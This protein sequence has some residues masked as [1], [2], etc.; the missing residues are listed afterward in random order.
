MK[1]GNRIR[2]FL[3]FQ[4]TGLIFIFFVLFSFFYYKNKLQDSRE[5]IF[6]RS[7]TISNEIKNTFY[8][9]LESI[10]ALNRLLSSS[11]IHKRD[12]VYDLMKKNTEKTKIVQGTF[13]AFD[14]N[15]FDYRDQEYK[16]T[17]YHD[18]TGRV[19][20]YIARNKE[21]FVA[22]EVAIGYENAN[23][24]EIIRDK[25]EHLIEPYYDTIDGI[26]LQITSFSLPVVRA[27]KIIGVVG[28]DIG[29]DF[30]QKTYDKS[31]LIGG[32]GNIYLI[33]NDGNYIVNSETP[34]LKG[35]TFLSSKENEILFNEMKNGNG[36]L[37]EN[38]NTIKAFVPISFNNINEKWYLGI[39]F[40]KNVILKEIFQTLG[41][42]FIILVFLVLL[43]ILIL[44]KV[45]KY[46]I[47]NPLEEALIF[48]EKISSGNYK[49]TK[50]EKKFSGEMGTLIHAIEEIANSSNNLV[51]KIKESNFKISETSKSLDEISGNFLQTSEL[52]FFSIERT[53][54]SANEVKDLSEK[55]E[56]SMLQS[57]SEIESIEKNISELNEKMNFMTN[58]MMELKNLSDLSKKEAGQ[59][60]EKV[61][62]SSKQ[63][64]EIKKATSEINKF[65][66]V[67]SDISSKTNLLA[68]N[69]AI[70]AARA[71]ETGR[72]F[73][74]VADEIS[75]LASQT[76]DSVKSIS[77]IMLQT[78]DAL[79]KGIYQVE[80]SLG[81]F[82]SIYDKSELVNESIESFKSKLNLSKES[83][84]LLKKNT[85][86]LTQSSENI[87]NSISSQKKTSTEMYLSTEAIKD[88]ANNILIESKKINLS[89]KS[90][91]KE[92][93]DLTDATDKFEV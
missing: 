6:S 18:E 45:L 14:P 32:Y 10:R 15:Q 23:W 28:I 38:F 85:K 87:L 55:I 16:F 33:S 29:M 13:A 34:E 80:S 35:K 88:L 1:L 27:D 60:K 67:I 70:E 20:A 89:S 51:K 17:K 31:K 57:K 47:Y 22:Q 2:N 4:T 59:G 5:M 83:T 68:L 39:Y 3:Y 54:Q 73:S 24:Y 72:G 76:V 44:S 71:G 62:D 64:I 86:E 93:K 92:V 19:V 56:F 25:K 79:K 81:L 37:K 40:P 61:F 75:K 84:D 82:Q 21:G 91:F 46:Q 30:L 78:D 49:I 74:V 77:A 66:K 50:S 90:L 52:Q 42:I 53:N 41:L 26:T 69:A 12:L 65:A 7:Q 11:T 58:E 9:E 43:T 63:L 8:G 36:I 48:S